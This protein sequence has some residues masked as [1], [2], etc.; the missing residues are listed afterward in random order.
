VRNWAEVLS[1][2]ADAGR[3]PDKFSNLMRDQGI[4]GGALVVQPFEIL[5]ARLAV[6]MREQTRKAGLSLGD[7]ACLALGKATG[8]PILSA[9][10]AW[11]ELG[12]GLEIQLI[13]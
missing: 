13:R 4:L 12:L 8:Y 5:H 7:K 2:L 1:R 6:R 9:D 10:R 11:A 3:D